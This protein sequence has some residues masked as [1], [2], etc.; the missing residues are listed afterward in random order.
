MCTPLNPLLSCM[1]KNWNAY[2]LENASP[3]ISIYGGCWENLCKKCPI[4]KEIGDF[5]DDYNGDGCPLFPG[6]CDQI[7]V[8]IFPTKVP[9]L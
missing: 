1:S 2:K 5:D 9:R 4:W 3:K 6:K 8:N 7:V